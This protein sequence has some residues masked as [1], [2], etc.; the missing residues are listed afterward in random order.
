MKFVERG[1]RFEIS[2]W[3]STVQNIVRN[4]FCKILD[5]INFR[6]EVDGPRY[7]QPPIPSRLRF[8]WV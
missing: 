8:D 6:S 4:T 1:V 5:F 2:R 3:I 7:P